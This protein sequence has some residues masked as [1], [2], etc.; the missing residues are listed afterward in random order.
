MP[1]ETLDQIAFKRAKRAL[2]RAYKRSDCFDHGGLASHEV[3]DWVMAELRT[4]F[5]GDKEREIVHAHA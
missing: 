1:R 4:E 3:F 2:E 5:L